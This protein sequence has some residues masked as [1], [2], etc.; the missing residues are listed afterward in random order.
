ME[1]HDFE[2]D[3]RHIGLIPIV[4]KLLDVVCRVTGMRF[5]A[6]ARVTR[7]KWITCSVLD[8]LAFGLVPGSELEVKTTIC[9]EIRDSEQVVVIDCVDTDPVFCNHPTPQMY[10]FQS[11][12][13]M[14]VF[15]RDGRFFGTLCAIDPQP[16]I[17]NTPEIL[18][19]FELFAELISFHLEVVEQQEA[20]GKLPNAR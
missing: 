14:P 5:A 9:D 17:L 13:S 4:P 12:I 16:R 1:A 18:E 19:M 11:Y 20:E 8:N 6:I 15:R 3:I 10:G 2:K 7:E